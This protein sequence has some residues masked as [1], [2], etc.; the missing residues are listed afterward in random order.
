MLFDAGK[1]GYFLQ[2]NT[3]IIFLTDKPRYGLIT[4]LGIAIPL[5]VII[6]IMFSVAI[7]I[8]ICTKRREEQ[9]KMR[10]NRDLEMTTVTGTGDY[11]LRKNGY[12]ANANDVDI[13][14]E[15]D[16]TSTRIKAIASTIEH[17]GEPVRKM[18]VLSSDIIDILKTN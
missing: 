10:I 7:C 6:C 14:D 15:I 3:S 1:G 16:G 5:F 2:C 11:S 18:S 12:H 13:S 17:M 9:R 8:P 4:G